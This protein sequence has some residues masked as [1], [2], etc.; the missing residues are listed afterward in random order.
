MATESIIEDY[1]QEIDEQLTS[2]DSSVTAVKTMLEKLMSMSRS[3]QLQK[4]HV[5]LFFS[6]N[7]RKSAYLIPCL[8]K[9]QVTTC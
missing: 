2:F 5:M 7:L 4:V 8:E 9:A 1:P 3:E 6:V